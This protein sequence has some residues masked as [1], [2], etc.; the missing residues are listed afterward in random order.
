M[1]KPKQIKCILGMINFALKKTSTAKGRE[2]DGK[3]VANQNR[4]AD[5]WSGHVERNGSGVPRKSMSCGLVLLLTHTACDMA[6]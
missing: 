2:R 3:S 4:E 1:Q 6:E 5:S